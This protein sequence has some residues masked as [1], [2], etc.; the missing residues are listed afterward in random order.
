MSAPLLKIYKRMSWLP[1]GKWMFS[2]AVCRK[3]PYFGTIKPKITQLKPGVC[4]ATIRNRKAI[5][6]HIGTVHAIAQCNLAELCAGVMTDATIDHKTH[7][8]IPKGMS[9]QYL[10]KAETDLH[11]VAQIEYPRAWQDKEELVVPVEVFNTAGEKVF[12]ADINMYISAKRS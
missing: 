6:N 1:F 8:W 9:V 7:R 10:A 4:R 3:A 5:H 11:A 2:K 12:H